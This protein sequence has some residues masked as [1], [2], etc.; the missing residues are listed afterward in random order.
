M[1]E[2]R[3]IKTFVWHDGKCY[4]VSTI[5]RPSSA[6][7]GGRFAETIVWEYGWDERERGALIHQDEALEDCISTHLRVVNNLHLTG[8]PK[9]ARSADH[10]A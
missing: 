4:F 7:Y 5:N 2:E 6:I 9:D 8:S 1:T 3:V 10:D